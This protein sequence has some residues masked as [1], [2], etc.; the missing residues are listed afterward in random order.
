MGF[1]PQVVGLSGERITGKFEEERPKQNCFHRGLDISSSK[2]PK[3]F[4]AGLFGKVVSPLG[5]EWGTVT[6]LPFH[7]SGYTV[8]YLHCSAIDVGV[9]EVI[10]PWT[11][12]GHTGD[13]A[14]E[15]SGVNGVH[16]HVHV[17]QPSGSKPK[18]SCWGRLNYEDPE[19]FNLGTPW[20]G[21]WS[22][23]KN[24]SN[25][26]A[27][28]TNNFTS[29]TPGSSNSYSTYIDRVL[30]SRS[31]R[32]CPIRATIEWEQRITRYGRKSLVFD[33]VSTRINIHHNPCRIR[34]T[35]SHV[36]NDSMYLTS[37]NSYRAF[38]QMSGRFS[39]TSNLTW[40]LTEDNSQTVEPDDA[41]KPG[42]RSADLANS[43]EALELNLDY[44]SIV[45]GSEEIDFDE[46]VGAL[47]PEVYEEL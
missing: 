47:P 7:A 21:T 46:W 22:M 40:E 10:A 30:I 42:P 36:R 26:Y 13:K 5:S 9:G 44:E 17:I 34:V 33:L 31:G 12:L 20:R 43:V 35:H 3:P 45:Y 11:T 14:P 41:Y 23:R 29:V 4:T 18:H 32:R 1:S 16:L 27:L 38:G 37:A 15:G 25:G 19:G 8:Q 2:R 28:H 24:F 39:K 6:V